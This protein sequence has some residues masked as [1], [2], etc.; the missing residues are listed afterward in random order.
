MK[1]RFIGGVSSESINWGNYTGDPAKL[2]EGKEY[3]LRSKIV[4]S[5]HTELF[6]EELPGS[7]NSVWFEE[8]DEATDEKI[9]LA[10]AKK[11]PCVGKR[12]ECWKI[13]EN[14]QLVKWATSDVKAVERVRSN[15]Y[16]V[17]T[18]NSIY[19]VQVC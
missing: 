9:Y 3:S 6:L 18:L 14:G 1:I 16:K 13:A 4:H 17:T 19:M 7:F 10:L 12:C 11:V 8:V 5:W 15:L 2:V